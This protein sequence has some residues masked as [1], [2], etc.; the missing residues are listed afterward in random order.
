MG[1]KKKNDWPNLADVIKEMA[2]EKEAHPPV[3]ITAPKPQTGWND[4]IVEIKSPIMQIPI[5]DVVQNVT[6]ALNENYLDELI[7]YMMNKDTE[8]LFSKLL[9]P[10]QLATDVLDQH[11]NKQTIPDPET[12]M[13]WHPKGKPKVLASEM[14]TRHLFFALRMLY[15]QAVPLKYRIGTDDKDKRKVTVRNHDNLHAIKV[16]FYQ[17]GLRDNI[18]DEQFENLKYMAKVLRSESL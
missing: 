14:E 16:L 3:F 9:N 4:D 11:T 5:K 10:P 17:I 6:D 13:W 2:A 12:D 8:E 1:T 18:T 7:K 15:N